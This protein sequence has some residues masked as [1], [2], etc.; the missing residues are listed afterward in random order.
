[1]SLFEPK[2][3]QIGQQPIYQIERRSDKLYK[4]K[5]F[6][7]QKGTETGKLYLAKKIKNGLVI[8]DSLSFGNGRD[9]SGRSP[10]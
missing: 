3:I 1:M 5:G 10:N 6:Y 9:L 4:M 7:R 8:V 2:S